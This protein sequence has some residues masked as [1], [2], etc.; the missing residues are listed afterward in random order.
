MHQLDE[1]KRT[2]KLTA[3]EYA[4]SFYRELDSKPLDRLLLRRFAGE[5]K[6]LGLT[7]DIGC[8]CGHT[9]AYLSHCGVQ[10]LVGI[11]LSPEMISQARRL[12][13]EIKFETGNMLDLAE[14]GN[15]FGAILAFY[16]IVHC[17]Y[18]EI[19]RALKEFWRTLKPGGLLLFSFHVG[20]GKTELDEFLGVRTR[21][22]FYYF[23]V[24]HIHRLLNS[25]GF[26]I[27]ETVI[28]Y[29]YTEAEYPSKRAYITARKR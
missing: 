8:G 11:D 5:A 2:Y 27:D 23:D 1:V 3:A 29:P 22:T 18:T 17:N 19:E 10:N 6:D 20:E 25:A 28:R 14:T 12:N 26:R 15:V 21:I 4:E 13:P 9:T 7:A 24:D 16:A